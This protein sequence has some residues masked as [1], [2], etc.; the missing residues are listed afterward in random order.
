MSKPLELIIAG[1]TLAIVLLGTLI[2]MAAAG[3][4]SAL[5]AGAL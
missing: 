1:A 3:L 2:M 4:V 5:M